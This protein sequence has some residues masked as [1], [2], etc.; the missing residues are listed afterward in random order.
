MF[1]GYR[2]VCEIPGFARNAWDAAGKFCKS[3]LWLPPHSGLGVQPFHRVYFL[4]WTV[5]GGRGKTQR[6]PKLSRFNTFP[7]RACVPSLPWTAFAAEAEASREHSTSRIAEQR[8]QLEHGF[9]CVLRRLSGSLK[10]W[11]A[12]CFPAHR[13]SSLFGRVRWR[14]F[15]RRWMLSFFVHSPEPR[16]YASFHGS[17]IISCWSRPMQGCLSSCKRRS[18]IQT[19]CHSGVICA[20]APNVLPRA[21]A[22]DNVRVPSATECTAS[23]HTLHMP[24]SGSGALCIGMRTLPCTCTGRRFLIQSSFGDISVRF[25]RRMS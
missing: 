13:F 24:K 5:A 25:F 19:S 4:F 1:D 10:H 21:Q 7:D 6:I 8:T 3:I 14:H 9:G 16:W 22:C 23:V 15:R 20:T 17:F 11:S 18:Q 2:V 12:S